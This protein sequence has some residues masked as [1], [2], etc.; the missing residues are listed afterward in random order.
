MKTI[1]RIVLRIILGV[2]KNI[3]IISVVSLA[4]FVFLILLYKSFIIL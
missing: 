3:I 4:L 1:I 2:I